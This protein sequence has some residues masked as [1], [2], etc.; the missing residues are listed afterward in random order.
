MKIYSWFIEATEDGQTFFV[1]DAMHRWRLHAQLCCDPDN[2]AVGQ[3]VAVDINVEE[4][5]IANAD[6]ILT[7]ADYIGADDSDP[8][9]LN[10]WLVGRG[11]AQET[12]NEIT[13]SGDTHKAMRV[14]IL[15]QQ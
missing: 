7:D 8:N 14:Y 13:E 15:A 11:V 10:A 1:A 12:A 2:P 5:E 4:S 3:I 6:E 9:A